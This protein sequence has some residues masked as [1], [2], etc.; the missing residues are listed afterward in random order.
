MQANCK[1]LLSKCKDP[2]FQGSLIT[3]GWGWMSGKHKC[4]E[5]TL[6]KPVLVNLGEHLNLQMPMYWALFSPSLPP[7]LHKVSLLNARSKWKLWFLC[8][9]MAVRKAALKTEITAIKRLYENWLRIL[10]FTRLN[11]FHTGL[12]PKDTRTDTRLELSV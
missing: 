7:F 8:T 11:T 3:T 2:L 10:L 4:L 9:T 12:D 6:F 1:R 5:S